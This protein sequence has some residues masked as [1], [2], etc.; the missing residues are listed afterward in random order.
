[1]TGEADLYTPPSVLRLQAEHLPQA[2][3]EVI[4]EAGHHPEWEQPKIF[5]EILLGFLARHA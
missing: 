2:E 5:N 1:V 4:S 3:V